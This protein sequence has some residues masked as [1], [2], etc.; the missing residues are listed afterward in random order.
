MVE[1]LKKSLKKK[2]AIGMLDCIAEQ[3]SAKFAVS[4]NDCS[5]RRFIFDTNITY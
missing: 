3:F 2:P 4:L 1:L 5:L